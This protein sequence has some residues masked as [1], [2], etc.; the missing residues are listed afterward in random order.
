[1]LAGAALTE[2]ERESNFPQRKNSAKSC[3]QIDFLFV[4]EFTLAY[5]ELQD[6]WPTRAHLVTS[7]NSRN[8]VPFETR[9]KV[10]R[11]LPK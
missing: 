10:L 3:N 4:K 1:L 7:R 5:L 9:G 11:S 2:I 6:K 8:S